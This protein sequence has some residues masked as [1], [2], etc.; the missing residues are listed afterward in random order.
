MRKFVF[1]IIRS[2]EEKLFGK[3]LLL[4][5]TV[6]SGFLM[7]IGEIIAQTIDRSKQAD[8]K[9][10]FVLDKVWLQWIILSLSLISINHLFSLH[11][12]GK[13]QTADSC[14]HQSRTITSLHISLDGA[15][16]AWKR[17]IDCDQEDSLRPAHRES[18]LHRSLLLHSLLPR[19]STHQRYQQGAVC[20]WEISANLHCWLVHLA[21]CTAAELSLCAAEVSSAVHQRCDDVLQHFSVLCEESESWRDVEDTSQWEV[22]CMFRCQTKILIYLGFK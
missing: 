21:C 5:N 17:Q 7:Y 13:D 20:R 8:S 3:Y 2:T 11:F 19:Q 9:D 14:W 18:R 1:D 12:V 15:N 16:S 10:E 4:T 22:N 6:S